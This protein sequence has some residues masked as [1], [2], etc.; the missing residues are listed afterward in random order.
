[1]HLPKVYLACFGNLAMRKARATFASEFFGTAG[2][3][4][5]G[6]FYFEDPLN[7]AEKSA[8]SNANIVVLCSS[9]QEYETSAEA[10]A[11]K[12]KSIAPEKSLVLAGYPESIV[13]NLKAAGIDQFIHMKS[14]AIDVLTGFQRKLMGEMYNA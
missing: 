5:L 9:D 4:I 11:R 6:E 2:F 8:E 14:N 13:E 10:F 12:F 1:G 3:D 7:A